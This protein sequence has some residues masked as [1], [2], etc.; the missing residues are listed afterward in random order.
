MKYPDENSYRVIS[1]HSNIFKVQNQAKEVKLVKVLKNLL[2]ESSGQFPAVG[3]WVEIDENDVIV[4]VKERKNKISRKRPGK[5]FEEQILASNVDVMFI[6]T[7]LNQ[8]FN[9]NRIVRYVILARTNK[10]EPIIVLTKVDLCEDFNWYLSQ[11]QEK[12]SDIPIILTSA[13]QNI[14]INEIEKILNR[15]ICT[16]IFIGSSGVGK[17]TIINELIENHKMKTNIIG[18]SGKGKH[19]TTHRELFVLENNSCII[20][21][22]G[23]REVGLWIEDV[24]TALSDDITEFAKFCRFKNCTHTVEPDCEIIRMLNEG[25]ISKERYKNFIKMSKEIKYTIKEQETRNKLKNKKA[26]K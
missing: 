26:K 22:P 5:K 20:D 13:V 17:S 9:I 12:Y 19:T 25:L 10:I 14:G 1:A 2:R 11:I 8:D 21:T 23:M 3:D 24:N 15:N 16:A 18:K 4:N 7:S 6:L